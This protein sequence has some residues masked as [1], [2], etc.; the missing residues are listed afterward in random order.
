MET[1][2]EVELEPSHDIALHAMVPF[3]LSHMDFSLPPPTLP[4]KKPSSSV[5]VI[6]AVLHPTSVQMSSLPGYFL[7]LRI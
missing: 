1:G 6:C 4:S 7:L 3:F 5:P 2:L